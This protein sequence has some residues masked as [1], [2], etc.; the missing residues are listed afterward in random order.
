MATN[1][2]CWQ[3]WNVVSDT[4]VGRPLLVRGSER[5][6][7]DLDGR[8]VALFEGWGRPDYQMWDLARRKPL[9][10]G[11]GNLDLSNRGVGLLHGRPVLTGT[12]HK[13]LRVWDI[14]TER[15]LGTTDL[16][17]TPIATAIGPKDAVWGIT[18]TG[19]I[20]SLTVEPDHIHPSVIRRNARCRGG[21]PQAAE[22]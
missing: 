21:A 13:S 9:G 5:G 15:L 22:E 18:R 6:L 14:G 16:P 12:M 7:W 10:P 3:L 1:P 17:D 11:L 20:G 19:Y 8:P 4:P 2:G